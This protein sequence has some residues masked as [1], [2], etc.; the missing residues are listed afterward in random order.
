MGKQSMFFEAIEA[1]IEDALAIIKRGFEKSPNSQENRPYHRKK[2]TWHTK[3]P[4]GVVQRTEAILAAIQEVDPHLVSK[5][6]IALGRYSAAHHDTVQEYQVYVV[7]DSPL[8][9]VVRELQTGKN[10]MAS[11]AHAVASLEY[12]NKKTGQRIFSRGEMEMVEEAILVTIPEISKEWGTVI[13]PN[14]RE[15][16]GV[17]ARAVA[18]A[19]LGMAGMEGAQAFLEDGN[20]LFREFNLDMIGIGKRF[21]RFP[22]ATQEFY[23]DRMLAWSRFQIPFAKGRKKY[24]E[25]ELDGLPPLAQEAVRSLF[26]TFD[27]SIEVAEGQYAL[28][29]GLPFRELLRDV[30]YSVT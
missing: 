3:K 17:I 5:R 22:I 23:R 16:N 6:H 18:L 13:Q 21:Q 19:D 20:T 26:T 11:A 9:C 29:Q 8:P 12:I 30:G 28:R 15:S 4:R 7:E 2:H 10:E 1:G 14:L 25:H 27:E 24:L